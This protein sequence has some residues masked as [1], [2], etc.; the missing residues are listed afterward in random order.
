M[1]ELLGLLHDNTK[2]GED[3]NTLRLGYWVR[4]SH[5]FAQALVQ[6]SDSATEFLSYKTSLAMDA[7]SSF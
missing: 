1:T 3:A 7:G 2:L 4:A 6:V 5:A